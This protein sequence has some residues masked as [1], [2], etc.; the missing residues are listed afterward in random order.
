[1]GFGN[2]VHWIVLNVRMTG[3][4]G[5]VMDQESSQTDQSCRIQLQEG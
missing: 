1:L 4:N 5:V 3:S 2:V